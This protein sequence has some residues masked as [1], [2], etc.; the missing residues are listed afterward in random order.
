M[1][2]KRYP[3][4][5]VAEMADIPDEAQ[6]RMIADI[7]AMVRTIREVRAA[8][9]QL[10]LEM[11]AK[12]PWPFRHLPVGVFVAMIETSCG[13]K[14]VWIDD[15]KGLATISARI[16]EG[17]A[18][19][20]TRTERYTASVDERRDGHDPEEGHGAKPA[21]AVPA[22]PGDAQTTDLEQQS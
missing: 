17:S 20:Y 2:G 15:D 18:A 11:R 16:G 3:C 14:M 10:A 12:A 8:A 4:S 13:K 1:S 7:P 21:R 6:S 19:F 22:T 9:P 5:T